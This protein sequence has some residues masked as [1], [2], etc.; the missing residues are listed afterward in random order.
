MQNFTIKTLFLSLVMALGIVSCVHDDVYNTP[1][2]ANYECGELT[3]NLS[4]KDLK[5]MPLNTAITEDKIIE[6][7]VG[8]TDETGNIY[9]TIYVQDAP[10]NPTQGLA[11]SV[12]M[13]NTYTKFPQGSKIYVKVKGLA[14][15]QYGGAPQLG[16]P[17]SGTTLR[18]PENQVKNYILRSCSPKVNITPKVMTLADMNTAS[19][20]LLGALI[21]VNNAEFE[22]RNLCSTYADAGVS[23]DKMIVDPTTNVTTRVV[24]NSGYASF[25]NDR[26]PSGNG[27]IVAIYSKFSSTYQLL[28]NRKEDVNFTKFPRL[29]GIASDPCGFNPA[30]AQLLTVAQLKSLATGGNYTLLPNGKYIK[31]IIT[32]N[33][34]TGNFYKLFYAEDETGGIGFKVNKTNLYQDARFKVGKT[35][36]IKTDGLY[37]GSSF[38]ELQLGVPYNGFI[39]QVEQKDIYKY[40]FDEDLGFSNLNPTIRNIG[41]ISNNDLGRLVRIPS[42]QFAISEFDTNNILFAK[43]FALTGSSAPNMTMRTI[44]DCQ[45][46]TISMATSKFA[47]FAGNEIDAGKGDVIG[48]V[49]KYNN[50]NMIA[51]PNAVGADLDNPRCDGSIPPQRIFAERFDGTSLSPDWI[52]VSKKG[53]A[54]WSFQTYG[55]PAPSVVMN[56]YTGGPMENE[57]YLISKEILLTNGNNF[58]L[59]FESDVKNDGAPLQVFVTENY[60]GDPATTSWVALQPT[61]DTNSAAFNT[62]TKSGALSLNSYK[63]KKIRIAFKYISTTTAAATW[64][65]DNIFVKGS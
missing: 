44:E 39:G 7:Y 31:V 62:W 30:N 47:T 13:V 26:L 24:R 60:T 48:I 54:T 8:S 40:I 22:A 37:I 34:E 51:I 27:S 2:L 32:A 4:L 6:A 52:V 57:D 18:I 21:Q 5:M 12:D 41:D 19:N 33:D 35:I 42:V 23:V 64:Q 36:Y 65:L 43:T 46:K 38:G 55:N 28:I 50:T 14:M 3:P 29:D 58:I 16:L 15:G 49:I 45:G 63:N 53:T 1:A 25:A 10:T 17:G 59:S 11:I 9:K 56:G 61:L 20:D